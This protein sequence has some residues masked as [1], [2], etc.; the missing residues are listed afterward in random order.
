MKVSTVTVRDENQGSYHVCVL[1]VWPAQD[2]NLES[3]APETD[4]LS[5]KQTGQLV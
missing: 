1:R 5:I 4:A 2:S 3:L